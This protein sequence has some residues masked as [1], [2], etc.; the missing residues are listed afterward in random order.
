MLLLQIGTKIC[1]LGTF[2]ETARRF[3]KETSNVDVWEKLM[4]YY[5]K[6]FYTLKLSNSL[7]VDI[8]EKRNFFCKEQVRKLQC[9][10]K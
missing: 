5:I 3:F 7:K 10:P 1:E 9:S 8:F 6:T 4:R 2:N